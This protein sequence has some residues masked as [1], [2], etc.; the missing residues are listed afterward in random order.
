MESHLRSL[1][2]RVRNDEGG[3]PLRYRRPICLVRVRLAR[4]AGPS[5]HAG[6]AIFGSTGGA[7]TRLARGLPEPLDHMPYAL[8]TGPNAGEV[9]AGLSNGEIWKSRDPDDYWVR[10][11][12]KFPETNGR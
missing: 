7:W 3:R 12:V 1:F 5:D 8:V 11:E 9:V 6:A 2:R 4:S 10:L